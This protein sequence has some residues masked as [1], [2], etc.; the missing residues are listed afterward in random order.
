MWLIFLGSD[1]RS[2][3]RLYLVRIASDV[4]AGALDQKSIFAVNNEVNLLC[5]DAPFADFFV[6]ASLVQTVRSLAL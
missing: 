2:F 5:I 6:C 4:V 3:F 1:L